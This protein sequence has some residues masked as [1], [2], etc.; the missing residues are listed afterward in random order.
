MATYRKT[1]LSAAVAF[2]LGNHID[3]LADDSDHNV[4]AVEL[5]DGGGEAVGYVADTQ[6][7]G[8][9]S[10]FLVVLADGRRVRVTC[11]EVQ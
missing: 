10:T 4:R 8:N 2:E 6:A 1:P 11:E 9:D 3:D 7:G 5:P